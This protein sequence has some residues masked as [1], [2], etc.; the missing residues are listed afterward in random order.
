[1]TRRSA[2]DGPLR[3]RRRVAVASADARGGGRP[4]RT[5]WKENAMKT[6]LA[7]GMI[8]AMLAACSH[9]GSSPSSKSDW[10]SGL[11]TLERKYG[12]SAPEVHDAAVAALQGFDL[13][14]TTDRHDEMG[15]EIV[16]KRGDHSKVFV[17]VAALDAK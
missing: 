16:A 3:D 15:S 5:L 13:K 12:K 10:G 8:T 1:M 6:H 11:N 7:L 4:G 9:E 17:H 2:V 14:V